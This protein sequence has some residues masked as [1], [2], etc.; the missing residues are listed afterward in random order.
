VKPLCRDSAEI[1]QAGSKV[2]T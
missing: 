2:P 1:H